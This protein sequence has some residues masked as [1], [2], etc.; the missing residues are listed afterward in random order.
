[1]RFFQH[2]LEHVRAVAENQGT[3]VEALAA[4]TLREGHRHAVGVEGKAVDT[5]P[6]QHTRND[7]AATAVGHEPLD[8]LGLILLR[9]LVTRSAI[10]ARSVRAFSVE[11][12][13]TLHGLEIKAGV[14]AYV[15]H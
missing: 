10:A 7:T 2:G 15:H 9:E 6:V 12:V 4:G 1:M 11:W 5:R 14:T 8:I 13:I 3:E